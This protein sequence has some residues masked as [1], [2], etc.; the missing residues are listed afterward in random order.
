MAQESSKAGTVHELETPAA[1]A[2]SS[3]KFSP[4]GTHLLVSSWDR[5]L[6]VYQQSQGEVPFTLQQST[7]CNAPIL[8]A[9]FGSSEATAFYAGVDGKVYRVDWPNEEHTILSAHAQ[10]ANKVAY[11]REHGIVISTSWDGTV[12][13][14]DPKTK[15]FVRIGLPQKP[16]AL[17]LTAERATV[18]MAERK[19]FVYE[20]Q[21]LR[22]LLEQNGSTEDGQTIHQVQPWQERESSL[23]FMTR[24]VASMIDGAGFATS[25]I[26][27]RVGVEWF[28]PDS[29]N[30]TYAFKC[31]R[32]TQKVLDEDGTETEVDV[33]YP[34]NAIAFHPVHGTFATGGGDGVIAMWDAQTKRRVRQYQKLDTGIFDMEFSPNGKYL[35][36]GISPGIETDEE[37]QPVGP[38]DASMVKMYVRE[39]SEN[40]AKGKEPKAKTSK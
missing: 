40:E 25:S 29:Q 1:D 30:K 19:M 22:Q 6:Y 32:D 36:V 12:H 3:T 23:K 38:I 16:F 31:H 2:I 8:S 11:S 5:H 33:I 18:A 39:L 7:E 35:A 26:E 24:A 13:V 20:L 34:V 17:S 14:H 37:G 4:D 9:C 10:P 27:G 28:D 15:A 21:G